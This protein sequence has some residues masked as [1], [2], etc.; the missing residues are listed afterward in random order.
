ML[1]ACWIVV[2]SYWKKLYCRYLFRYIYL[3]LHLHLNHASCMWHEH[4]KL[5]KFDLKCGKLKYISFCL[6][7]RINNFF[8]IIKTFCLKFQTLQIY[9]YH[10]IYLFI[11]V[12]IS[13]RTTY[14]RLFLKFWHWNFMQ[15]SLQFYFCIIYIY[16]LIFGLYF[17]SDLMIN[18]IRNKEHRFSEKYC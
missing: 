9:T 7:S 11:F 12:F 10:N 3:V 1:S 14:R 17:A 13:G 2:H 4:E 8:L 15:I 16:T 6:Y 5:A 18:Y